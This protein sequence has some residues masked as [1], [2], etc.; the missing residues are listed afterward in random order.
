MS[1]ALMLAAWQL[2]TSPSKRDFPPKAL[3]LVC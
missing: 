3:S 1:P 2:L